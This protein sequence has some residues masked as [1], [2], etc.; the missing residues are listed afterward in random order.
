MK[1]LVTGAGGF[2]G[3]AIAKKLAQAGYD[4]TGTVR[5][6]SPRPLPTSGLAIAEADLSN[7]DSLFALGSGF[8]AV[9]HAAA[10][11]DRPGVTASQ[12]FRDNMQATFNTVQFAQRNEVGRFI[13]MSSVSVHGRINGP[14]VDHETPIIDP[15]PY[16]YSKRLGELLLNE[17][18]DGLGAV[19]LRLPGVVGPGGHSNWLTRTC[20]TLAAGNGI[21]IRNPDARFNNAVHTDDLSS[22]CEALLHLP[23]TGHRAMPLAAGGD[24]S[25]RD[26][27]D[28]LQA[29]LGGGPI[30]IEAGGSAPFVIDDGFARRELNYRSMETGPLLDRLADD[31]RA[32][33]VQ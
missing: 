33:K 6:G 1:I 22:F 14:V 20:E 21:T 18:P 8:T 19:S 11:V 25:I 7:A 30:K 13:Y 4:V 31:I 28:R 23:L 26:V 10:T 2:A 17:I 27:A 29:R 12:L 9:I 16:G 5:P 32:A 15:S 24:L 3:G